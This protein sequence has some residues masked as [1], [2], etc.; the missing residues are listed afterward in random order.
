[1][2]VKSSIVQFS[3]VLALM[4]AGAAEAHPYYAA[5]YGTV[6]VSNQTAAS[7]MVTVDGRAIPV[8]AGRTQSFQARAGDVYV[9]ATY[10][11][12]GLD[13]VLTSRQVSVRAYRSAAVVLTTPAV[14]YVKVENEADRPADLLVDGR[15]LT[16]FAPY[17]TRLV[18][19]TLGCHDLAMVAGTWTIDRQRLDVAPFAEPMFEAQMPRANDVVVVNPLPIPLQIVTDRG[20][21]RTVDARGQTVFD[22]VP[23][24]SFHLTARRVSGERVDDVVATVRP[25]VVGTWRV[26]PPVTGLVDVQNRE[27]MSTRLMIDGRMLRSLAPDQDARFELALGAHHVELIDERGRS[28]YESCVTV[29]PYDVSTLYVGSREVGRNDDGQYDEDRRDDGRQGDERGD[30]GRYD[31][32]ESHHRSDAERAYTDED[33]WDRQSDDAEHARH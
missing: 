31:D 20:L 12:F 7:M 18:A 1:M 13:R 21:V 10:R 32:G 28:V 9:R 6:V 23:L 26:D 19:M 22:S 2:S 29:Q 5:D 25:D 4:G 8:G 33:R 24:G 14:G 11:Q 3:T 16:S 27:P 30:E 15:V 17:Q